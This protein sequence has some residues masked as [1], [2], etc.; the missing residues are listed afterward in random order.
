MAT[1]YK[2]TNL[3]KSSPLQAQINVLAYR[4][5]AEYWSGY[6]ENAIKSMLPLS[7]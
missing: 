1:V 3:D 2:T 7:V 6:E 4:A 5:E